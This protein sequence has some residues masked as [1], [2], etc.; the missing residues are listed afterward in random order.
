MTSIAISQ[1]FTNIELRNRV[2]FI[3]QPKPT[4]YNRSTHPT[5]GAS[6]AGHLGH[7]AST[8]YI[9][10]IQ[11]AMGSLLGGSVFCKPPSATSSTGAPAFGCRSTAMLQRLQQVFAVEDSKLALHHPHVERAAFPTSWPASD[12]LPYGQRRPPHANAT[13]LRATPAG[14]QATAA[15]THRA[16]TFRHRSNC[17]RSTDLASHHSKIST[18]GL[19]VRPRNRFFPSIRHKATIASR[20]FMS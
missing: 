6:G 19:A 13:S 4:P 15:R 3:L 12:R 2:R 5:L 18:T 9:R 11:S 14:P 7:N 16:P 10:S 17:P 1:R 20:L 8:T